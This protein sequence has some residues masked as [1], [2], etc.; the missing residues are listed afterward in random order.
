MILPFFNSRIV[1][2]SMV[3]FCSDLIDDLTANGALSQV[4][5][6]C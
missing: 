1:E 4:T 3:I 5:S 2:N 6:G